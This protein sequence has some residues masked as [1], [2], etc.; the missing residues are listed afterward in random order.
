MPVSALFADLYEFTML[1]AYHALGMD[2]TAVFSLF[3][4]NLPPGRNFLVACGLET[5]L[6]DI[7]AFRFE[8]DD[9]A[10]LASLRK[11]RPEFLSWLKTFR[12]CG[13]IWA[14]PEGTPVFANE[15]I[16]EIVA[17]IAQGQLLETL[18]LNQIGHQTLIASKTARIVEAARAREVVDFGAR[19][20]HGLDAAM[21]GA[22]AAFIAGVS[23][24]S[25]VQAAGE[26]GIPVSGTVAHSYIQAFPSEMDAFRTLARLFPNTTLLVDTY[27]TIAGVEAVV[28]LARELGTSFRI[29]AVRLD[30]GDLLE[31]T[32][33]AR[34]ILDQAGLKDVRIL[35]SGSLDEWKIDRLVR[36][37][38]PI[39]AFG[40][41]T[42]MIVSSD[43]PAF[44]IAYKLT[45]YDGI[46]RMKLS[47]GKRTLPGRK[48]VFRRFEDSCAVGDLIARVGET[49]PGRALLGL[50]MC[51]GRRCAEPQPLVQ[52]R[53]RTA[54]MIAEL[55]APM[56]SLEAAK[57]H[58]PVEIS[59]GLNA[60]EAQT[61]RTLAKASRPT[62]RVE[63]LSRL[64]AS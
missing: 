62:S 24:T 19:R 57:P 6:D 33:G 48:Q 16:I 37:G 49:A 63:P 29:R 15:P 32:R 14:V 45:E 52:I 31:L 10:H 5:L 44:D 12:F 2:K 61:R 21:K 55:P 25:N 42:D 34:R 36:E 60:Y 4:R 22:R 8:D 41:G 58:Y 43:A 53:A 47:T 7:E 56:R 13:D 28:V 38:A 64:L 40:V 51:Q 26:Y 11:F 54:E 20:A 17:P 39:D 46:G 59:Q 27:D 30:S 50:K 1:E 3:V 23:A 9:I 18:V 35:A